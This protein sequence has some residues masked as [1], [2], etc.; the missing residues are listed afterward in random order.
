MS[1]IEKRITDVRQS[2]KISRVIFG[3]IFLAVSIVVSIITFKLSLKLIIVILS[4]SFSSYL[5]LT[6][7][8]IDKDI[9]LKIE[10]Y[11]QLKAKIHLPT[12]KT[13]NN[14]KQN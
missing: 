4:G 10:D 3:F 9:A 2:Y 12:I 8:R 11:L 7:Q 14:T 1:N 13:T 5:F 6:A